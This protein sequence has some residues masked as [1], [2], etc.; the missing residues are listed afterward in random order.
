[1]SA[2]IDIVLF[3]L[4]YVAV[5]IVYAVPMEAR[6]RKAYE[7]C[8]LKDRTKMVASNTNP[9]IDGP[10][11]EVDLCENNGHVH[12]PDNGVIFAYL[13]FWPLNMA[14]HVIR[15]LGWSLSQIM[16]GI[17][18]LIFMVTITPI[19]T[20]N[21]IEQKIEARKMKVLVEATEENKEARD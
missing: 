21:V 2:V 15:A 17:G 13:W 7:S 16:R 18:L 20:V 1:M 8:P 14:F 12:H 5:G 9:W 6:R 11:V 4:L 3:F 19:K 10:L